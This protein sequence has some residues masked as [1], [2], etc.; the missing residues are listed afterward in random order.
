MIVCL[1][2]GENT[3]CINHSIDENEKEKSE[4]KGERLVLVPVGRGFVCVCICV[5]ARVF[6][7]RP[8]VLIPLLLLFC[9]APALMKR[10]RCSEPA[11]SSL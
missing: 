8:L 1:K 11:G 6:C 3:N 7:V 5:C 10:Q 9:Q 2:S 4:Q